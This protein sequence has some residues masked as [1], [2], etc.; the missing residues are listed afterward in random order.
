MKTSALI[1]SALVLYTAS[2]CASSGRTR[3]NTPF[4]RT[5]ITHDQLATDHFPN[6]YEAV[7]ALRSNWLNVRPTSFR[8]PTRV[9]VYLDDARLGG[10]E[11]L[12]TLAISAIAYMRHYD[13]LAATGRW[14]VDHGGGAIYV[15]T[16]GTR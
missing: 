10:V 2:G 15:S 11:M 3:P 5:L 4:D 12:R 16:R 9:Q 14:G 13:G 7:A 6:A 8:A 1:T